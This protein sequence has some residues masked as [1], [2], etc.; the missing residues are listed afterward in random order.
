[1]GHLV[2][3]SGSLAVPYS[4][5]FRILTMVLRFVPACARTTHALLTS[6]TPAEPETG[7]TDFRIGAFSAEPY[8]PSLLCRGAETV[9]TSSV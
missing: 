4:T 7:F 2:A 8:R 9:G 6:H 1:M 3:S 5:L